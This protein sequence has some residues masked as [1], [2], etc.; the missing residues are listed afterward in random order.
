[1]RKT[2]K[3]A[4]I[5]LSAVLLVVIG[6]AGTMAYFTW[7]STVEN[8]FTVGKVSATVDESKVDEYGNPVVGQDGQP[9]GERTSGGNT[10][11]VVPGH[12]YTKD[13]VIH[14]AANSE[15]AYFFVKVENE[16]AALETKTEADTVIGQLKANGW[17]LLSGNVYWKSYKSAATATDI[18]TFA[19]F[20]VADDV[21]NEAEG[22][23][24][25]VTTYGVQADG[26]ATAADAWN[27]TFGAAK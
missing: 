16:I 12:K 2:L 10:Y 25:T 27:A 1:M 17:T 9:T 5:A 4:L 22:G 15:D 14:V 13:P 26:F 19:F 21:E 7:S 20:K 3:V 18:A 8:T 24:I 11:N 6:A 23:K